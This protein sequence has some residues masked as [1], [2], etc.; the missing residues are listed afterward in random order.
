MSAADPVE[1]AGRWFRY[2]QEDLAAGQG[3]LRT[4]AG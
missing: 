4:R 1:E 2:V 3:G